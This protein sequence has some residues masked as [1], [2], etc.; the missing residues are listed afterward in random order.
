MPIA[1]HK[2]TRTC[3][4]RSLYPL[5]SFMSYKR[6]SP[7]YKTFVTSLDSIPIPQI[8]DE[9]FS[10]RKWKEAI[11]LEMKALEENRI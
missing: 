1:L 4:K 3:T 5:N 8:V 6:L 7:S 11:D 2:G 10:H 9:V